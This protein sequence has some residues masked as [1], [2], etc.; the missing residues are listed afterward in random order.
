MGRQAKIKKGL[1]QRRSRKRIIKTPEDLIKLAQDI[2]RKFEQDILA[3]VQE[4]TS[5]EL[6][7]TLDW[8]YVSADDNDDIL[9]GKL[10]TLLKKL[11]LEDKLQECLTKGF[12]RLNKDEYGLIWDGDFFD[13]DF[14]V[15]DPHLDKSICQP[16]WED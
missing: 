10:E 16:C 7:E 13:S 1:I 2:K 4:K 15:Y 12:F 11:G 5:A 6:L 14:I 8:V 9:Y 3:L